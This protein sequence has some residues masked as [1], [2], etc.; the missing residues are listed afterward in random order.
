MRVIEGSNDKEAWTDITHAE[1]SAWRR[2]RHI[3]SRDVEMAASVTCPHV[4]TDASLPCMTCELL[5]MLKRMAMPEVSR[6]EVNRSMADCIRECGE[7]NRC[8][9]CRAAL[10]AEALIARVERG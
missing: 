6:C 4:R 1:P 10:E 7:Q 3:R 8:E 9:P 5:A 2:Y